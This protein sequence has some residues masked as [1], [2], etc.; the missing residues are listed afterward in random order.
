L[1]IATFTSC[2]LFSKEEPYDCPD[3]TDYYQLSESQKRIIPY[4]GYDTIRMVSNEGDTLTCIGRG[5]QYFTTQK[6]EAYSD[7]GCGNHGTYSNYEA[8]KI[9]FVDSVKNE[10][11]ELV[12][13]E[14]A[15]VGRYKGGSTIYVSLHE[16]EGGTWDDQ[17]SLPGA[18]NFLGSVEIQGIVYSN[19]T[20]AE[21]DPLDT[22]EF[23][24]I[25]KTNGIIKIQLSNNEI[26][27]L[28]KN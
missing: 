5:K 21:S 15:V 22:A 14:Q 16:G 1:G 26:W 28:I 19:V 2:S 20:K 13:C 23:V 4:T 12:H 7:P 11:I 17:I 24:L 18:Y 6:F 10:K 3:R 8:Y 27:E 25:N 9:E